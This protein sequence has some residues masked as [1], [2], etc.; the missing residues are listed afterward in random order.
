M[1]Q[2]SLR[3]QLA[4]ARSKGEETLTRNIQVQLERLLAK[5]MEILHDAAAQDRL[6][7]LEWRVPPG[8][9]KHHGDSH[10]ANANANANG[11]QSSAEKHA[12][13]HGERPLNLRVTGQRGGASDG[14]TPLGKQLANELK[15]HH[16]ASIESKAAAA[17]ENGSGGEASPRALNLSEKKT[18]KC[19]PE[20]SR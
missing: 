18:I 10:N 7:A 17:T 16:Q 2:E 1:R 3:E 9:F 8:A 12:E 6:Q 14:D 20:D 11:V 4:Q 13:Q 5:Q 15:R 19:E